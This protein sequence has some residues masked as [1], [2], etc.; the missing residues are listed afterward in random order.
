MA[1]TPDVMF[2]VLPIFRAKGPFVETKSV[3]VNYMVCQE[4]V[5]CLITC[6]HHIMEL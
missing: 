2:I 4:P 3:S 6:M 1:F 5:V